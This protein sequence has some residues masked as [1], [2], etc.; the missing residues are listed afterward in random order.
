M[1]EFLFISLSIFSLT[2][3]AQS[4]QEVRLGVKDNKGIDYLTLRTNF[5]TLTNAKVFGASL[6]Y[7]VGIEN[8]KLNVGPVGG[9]SIA[10]SGPLSGYT[11]ISRN[12]ILGETNYEVGA[13]IKINN[14]SRFGIAKMSS[15]RGDTYVAKYKVFTGGSH[16]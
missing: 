15:D 10:P 13:E 5:E 16:Q 3:F 9:I 14:D 11:T 12:L 1:K 6:G 4:N 2:A 7:D 8:G